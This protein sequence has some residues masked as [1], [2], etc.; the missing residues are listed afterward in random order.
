MNET[1]VVV[2]VYVIWVTHTEFEWKLKIKSH[3]NLVSVETIRLHKGYVLH[4]KEIFASY[5][6]VVSSFMVLVVCFQTLIQRAYNFYRLRENTLKV[7][8]VC[9]IDRYQ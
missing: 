8:V 7:E 3:E 4:D 1:I 2:E 6:P 5:I 9:S